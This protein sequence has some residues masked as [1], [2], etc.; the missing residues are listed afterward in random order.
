MIPLILLLTTMELIELKMFQTG[1]IRKA[2]LKNK[3]HKRNDGFHKSCDFKSL[4][5]RES[6]RGQLTF[7]N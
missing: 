6:Y 2:N 7:Y 4:E 1:A 3:S 5:M